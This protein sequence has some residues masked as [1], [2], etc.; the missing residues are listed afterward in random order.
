MA[1]DAGVSLG[2]GAWDCDLQ[3]EI[4]PEKE[5]RGAAALPAPARAAAR[6]LARSARRAVQE[7]RT[8]ASR[9]ET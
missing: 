5:A 7:G 2:K 4:M 1:S 9:A 6:L 8:R 3:K